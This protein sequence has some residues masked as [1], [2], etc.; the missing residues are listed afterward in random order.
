MKLRKHGWK[1]QYSWTHLKTCQYRYHK[2]L[3]R[4]WNGRS[5]E[6]SPWCPRMGS[7]RSAASASP[8][9]SPIKHG[10]WSTICIMVV[11]EEEI[12]FLSTQQKSLSWVFPKRICHEK[13]ISCRHKS[14]KDSI[15]SCSQIFKIP[16][17]FSSTEISLKN[18]LHLD[19]APP[20]TLNSTL[21]SLHLKLTELL[22]SGIGTN[23]V[24]LEKDNFFKSF[25]RFFS[26]KDI[27]F[28][29]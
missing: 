26:S 25:I 23:G 1:Q 29:G 9:Y 8:T 13:W 15:W 17:K 12:F 10:K 22:G 28:P 27:F 6:I 2:L 5:F 4:S 11:P 20:S 21:T 19:R 18:L 3:E 16:E 7:R 24:K 14:W